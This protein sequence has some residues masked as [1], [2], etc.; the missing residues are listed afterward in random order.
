ME[1]FDSMRD[2]QRIIEAEGR[3]VTDRFGQKKKN[4]MC[5]VEKDGRSQMLSC[6]KMLNLDVEPSHDGPGRPV[7]Q[8]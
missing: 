6:L 4:E 2:A 1:P 3:M 7:N 8:Y 5:M